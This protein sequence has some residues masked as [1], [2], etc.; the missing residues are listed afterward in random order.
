MSQLSSSDDG[1]ERPHVASPPPVYAMCRVQD[2]PRRLLENTT[3]S[4]NA[5]SLVLSLYDFHLRRQTARGGRPTISR[6]SDLLKTL[7]EKFWTNPVLLLWRVRGENL[8]PPLAPDHTWPRP[9]AIDAYERHSMEAWNLAYWDS[10]PRKHRLRHGLHY[11]TITVLASATDTAPISK[12]RQ[13]T[14]HPYWPDRYAK[15]RGLA[16]D[17]YRSKNR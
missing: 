11:Q 12:L 16:I 13:A 8:T 15:T 7:A 10:L 17:T 6:H 2:L 3:V 9:A 14:P 1:N 4:R 5:S